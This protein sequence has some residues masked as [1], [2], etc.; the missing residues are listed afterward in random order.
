M[1]NHYKYLIFL[2]SFLFLFFRQTSWMKKTHQDG[3][4]PAGLCAWRVSLLSIY[5]HCYNI[6]QTKLV[7]AAFIDYSSSSGVQQSP[8]KMQQQRNLQ[9]C[10]PLF[11]EVV[12]PSGQSCSAAAASCSLPLGCCCSYSFSGF[13][14]ALLWHSGANFNFSSLLCEEKNKEHEEHEEEEVEEEGK[15]EKL[16]REI[17]VLLRQSYNNSSS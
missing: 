6:I 9:S 4:Q 3:K 10:F 14:S 12:I 13:C 15:E 1:D 16:W 8:P 5:S 11:Q 7:S 17:T 2:F